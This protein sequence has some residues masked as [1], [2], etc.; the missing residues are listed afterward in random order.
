MNEKLKETLRRRF[1]KR[2]VLNI[3]DLDFQLDALLLYSLVELVLKRFLDI[4]RFLQAT[5][6]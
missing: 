1:F 4:R 3:V 2:K 5:T 6:P